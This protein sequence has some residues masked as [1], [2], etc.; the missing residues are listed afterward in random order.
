[1]TALICEPPVLIGRVALDDLDLDVVPGRA[2]SDDWPRPASYRR[3]APD[4]VFAGDWLARMRD[5]GASWR[6]LQ[7]WRDRHAW[8]RRPNHAQAMAW[9]PLNPGPPPVS[10]LLAETRVDGETERE[11]LLRIG[12]QVPVFDMPA[13]R[14]FQPVDPGWC[15]SVF[16]DS[17]ALPV[18]AQ[19]AM[20]A[21][22]LTVD[23]LYLVARGNVSAH[24]LDALVD[25]TCRTV[26]IALALHRKLTPATA[27]VLWDRA[28]RGA[29]RSLARMVM[30]NRHLGPHVRAGF[31]STLDPAAASS[32]LAR[33]VTQ[34]RIPAL[35]DAW[36]ARAA[37]VTLPKVATPSPRNAA[38]PR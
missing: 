23:R 25:D 9:Q 28:Q 6:L 27:R 8:Y 29:D 1:M 33:Q 7:Q 13:A 16:A 35:I 22:P 17:A 34:S 26:I 32:L 30:R 12:R 37:E 19:V 14:V 11:H 18:A 3:P 31:L 20:A 10:V 2:A 21:S 38:R 15:R 36:A 4:P 5:A 24:V